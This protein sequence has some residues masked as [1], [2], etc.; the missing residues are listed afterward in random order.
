MEI[1]IKTIQGLKHLDSITPLE[2]F[3][4]ISN[5]VSEL[6]NKVNQMQEL[7]NQQN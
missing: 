7:L 4:T 3:K 2:D 5:K 1:Y 6:E